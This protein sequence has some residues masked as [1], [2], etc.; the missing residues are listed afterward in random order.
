MLLYLAA[1][2]A[3][4]ALFL[5]APGIDLWVSGLFFRPQEGFFLADAWPVRALYLSVPWI[6][7]SQIVGIPLLLILGLWHRRPIAGIG[8]KQGVFVLL[9]LSH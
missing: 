7:A 5:L 8:L 9:V 3:A 4:G 1:M 6:V 2:V